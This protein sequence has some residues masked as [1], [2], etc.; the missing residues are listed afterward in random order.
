MAK[1]AKPNANLPQPKRAQ[2]WD[3]CDDN[4]RDIARIMVATDPATSW[5]PWAT[6]KRFAAVF[7]AVWKPYRVPRDR[8]DGKRYKP[9]LARAFANNNIT[10]LRWLRARGICGPPSTSAACAA[11]HNDGHA[12]AAFQWYLA[13]VVTP[14]LPVVRKSYHLTDAA[15]SAGRLDILQQL[16]AM[17]VH[18]V[19][20]VAKVGAKFAA[21]AGHLNVVSFLIPHA[22]HVGLINMAV[23]ATEG[24][25]F[26]I[27]EALFTAE[28]KQDGPSRGSS[29]SPGSPGSTDVP[30][31]AIQHAVY[32]HRLDVL[33]WFAARY[34]SL[35]VADL[36]AAA[37]ESCYL[38]VVEWVVAHLPTSPPQPQGLAEFFHECVCKVGV[39]THPSNQPEANKRTRGEQGAVA[40]LEW[41]LDHYP[42]TDLAVGQYAT[43]FPFAQ[44][45][46][47][48]CHPGLLDLVRRRGFV[49][50]PAAALR[51][52]IRMCSGGLSDL[53]LGRH[54][55]HVIFTLQWLVRHGVELTAD[56][57]LA[58]A[59]NKDAAMAS[60]IPFIRASGFAGFDAV[61]DQVRQIVD[62]QPFT[63]QQREL[64]AKDAR[65]IAKYSARYPL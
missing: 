6:C 53:Q 64:S 36:L 39:R 58:L 17:G 13:T 11:I 48:F 47:A 18:T 35:P 23:A 40:V 43:A 7:G 33:D 31:R 61:A 4:I 46:I 1:H 59:H 16:L 12:D 51:T 34:N 42:P 65:I 44:Y 22:T 62:L 25:Q 60:V 32:M 52:A 27:L 15:C 54:A 24:G 49:I 5:F 14:S 30:A 10:L 26:A 9:A 57:Y 20:Q 56:V 45:A 63:P 3:V 28:Q 8:R 37:I 41:A 29:G 2:L 21:K 50:D 55:G 19:A 38:P